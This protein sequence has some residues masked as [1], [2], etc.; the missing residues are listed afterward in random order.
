MPNTQR[1]SDVLQL[2]LA[3]IDEAGRELAVHL[4]MHFAGKRNTTRFSKSLQARSHVYPVTEEIA[5]ADH[6]IAKVDANAKL[7]LLVCR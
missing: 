7:D 6:D 4:I 1:T 2:V 3:R 5:I